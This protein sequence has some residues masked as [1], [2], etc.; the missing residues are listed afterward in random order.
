MGGGLRVADAPIT[1]EVAEQRVDA[2]DEP[3]MWVHHLELKITTPQ[4]R[5]IAPQ[6]TPRLRLLDARSRSVASSGTSRG[7]SRGSLMSDTDDPVGLAPLRWP[8]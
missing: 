3:Q 4:E 1:V 8:K 2:T 5:R 7:I 6:W